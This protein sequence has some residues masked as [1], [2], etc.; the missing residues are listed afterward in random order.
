M[1]GAGPLIN[2][3]ISYA[4]SEGAMLLLKR[5]GTSAAVAEAAKYIPALGTLLA[6]AVSFAAVRL[7][8]NIYISDCYKVA[9][10][11]LQVHFEI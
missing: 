2:T 4:T 5:V 1:P 9:D 10:E 7:V 3:I 11:M 6:G 8:L